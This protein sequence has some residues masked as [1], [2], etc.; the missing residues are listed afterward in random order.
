MRAL[1]IFMCN[2]IQFKVSRSIRE[3]FLDDP[4][5]LLRD[6]QFYKNNPLL[7]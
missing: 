7:F 2:L 1:L 6:G 4:E 3:S 5:V